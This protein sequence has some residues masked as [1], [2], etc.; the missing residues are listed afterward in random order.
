M[1][2]LSMQ[3]NN[4]KRC[5]IA[6]VGPTAVGKTEFA[7]QIAER[8][9][10]EIIS[11]DS[12]L[13]YKGMDIGTAKPTKKDMERV[14]HHLI[15]IAEPDETI[16]LSEY[17]EL[18][19]KVIG[20]I[21]SRNRI[22]FLV[23]GTGQYVK[24]FVEGWQIP[25]QPPDIRLRKELTRWGTLIGASSLH[26]RLSVIDPD[27]AEI[28]DPQNMRRTVRALEVIFST[29]KKFSVQRKKTPPPFGILMLGIKRERRELYQRIDCRVLQMIS[30][31][32]LDETKTL[33][34]QGYSP[35]LPAMSA[36][37]YRE[38]VNVLEN[39]IPLDEAIMVIKRR[40]RE[41]V[42]RQANWFKESD[43]NI[44]WIDAS[45]NLMKEAQILICKFL[46]QN[47]QLS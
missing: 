8:F 30:D 26:Q 29:G 16:S 20:K 28:V 34:D 1:N 42:R 17:Q 43:E 15:D 36:I 40:T 10:G 32:L 25:P 35:D 27:A 47:E 19:T 6:V 46:R 22:P 9:E 38:M 12:R 23:G 41:Y 31:G 11:A 24:A 4:V 44:H 5:L 18:A 39:R 45:D 7:I 21:H 13:F 3:F 33:L 2:G 14:P 37:G